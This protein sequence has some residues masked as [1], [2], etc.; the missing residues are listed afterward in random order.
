MPNN[1]FTINLNNDLKDAVQNDRQL[2]DLNNTDNPNSNYSTGK[3][4]NSGMNYDWSLVQTQFESLWFEFIQFTV[5]FG[6]EK[7]SE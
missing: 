6:N 2:I 4:T 5:H 7:L 1:K 3:V